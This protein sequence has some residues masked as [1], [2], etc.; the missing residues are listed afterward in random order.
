MSRYREQLEEQDELL[1]VLSVSV[2]RQK[3][4]ASNIGRETDEQLELLDDLDERSVRSRLKIERES[5]RVDEFSY[6]H[7]TCKLWLV[8]LFL[9]IVLCVVIVLALYLPKNDATTAPGGN[10]SHLLWEHE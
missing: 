2:Q 6:K 1:D 7:S 5:R 10:V 8:I 3:N 4:I 9:V